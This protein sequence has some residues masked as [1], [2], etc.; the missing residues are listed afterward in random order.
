M[1]TLKSPIGT[2]RALS[3]LGYYD[4]PPHRGIDDW[5]DDATFD[6][7]KKFQQDNDLKVDGFMRPGGPTEQ[8]MNIQL[9]ANETPQQQSSDKPGVRESVKQGVGAA[10]DMLNNFIDMR[11]ADWKFSDK[12]F[13]CKGNCEAT[14]R[15]PAGEATAEAIGNARE[16]LDQKL[17]GDSA[18]D[19]EEDQK[20][21]RT[22]RAA[23]RQ[24]GQSCG[25]ACGQYRPRG[26]PQRY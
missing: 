18:W 10:G 11:Q 2:K 23:G 16:W 17:K 13:H 3:D 19:S 21:N 14:R 7:I 8:K 6:G 12:Y 9:A 1:L 15:G 5:T 4:V 24:S 26:L 22:G 25:A 20:A